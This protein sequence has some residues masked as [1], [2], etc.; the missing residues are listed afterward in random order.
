MSPQKSAITSETFGACNVPSPT[1][2]YSAAETWAG[3]GRPIPS[4]ETPLGSLGTAYHHLMVEK[5]CF[6]IQPSLTSYIRGPEMTKQE[7]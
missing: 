3:A 4:K 1:A 6:F 5:M 7:G 2:S